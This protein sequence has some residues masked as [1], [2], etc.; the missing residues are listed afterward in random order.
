MN[1][2]A[3]GD[4]DRCVAKYQLFLLVLNLHES[5]K[6]FFGHCSQTIFIK[7]EKLDLLIDNTCLL[8]DHILGI[9]KLPC[10]G[11][12]L[13]LQDIIKSSMIPL[14][15]WPPIFI[16]ARTYFSTNNFSEFNIILGVVLYY[17]TLKV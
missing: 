12:L 11:K 5:F 16:D 3:C 8:P 9:I 2:L 15:H 6:L 4:N 7:T 14:H 1:C 17:E 10:F 13:K